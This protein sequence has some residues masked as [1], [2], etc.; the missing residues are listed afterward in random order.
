MAGRVHAPPKYHMPALATGCLHSQ[1]GHAR[2]HSTP[3]NETEQCGAKQDEAG[4]N[5]RMEGGT[6]QENGREGET[7]VL[8]TGDDYG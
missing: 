4:R 5:R 6:K 7:R 8:T 2:E 1:P 3:S